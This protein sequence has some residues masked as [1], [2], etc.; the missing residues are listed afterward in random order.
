M[1]QISEMPL[2]IGINYLSD[3]ASVRQFIQGS[4]RSSS[5][6]SA[7]MTWSTIAS[8]SASRA[9]SLSVGLNVGTMPGAPE[10][11]RAQSRQPLV[12][13]YCYP[14]ANYNGTLGSD[15]SFV[16][17]GDDNSELNSLVTFDDVFEGATSP[18]TVYVHEIPATVKSKHSALFVYGVRSPLV[19][20]DADV[21]ACVVDAAWVD[22]TLNESSSE[23]VNF[24]LNGANDYSLPL[25]SSS[26]ISLSSSL[27][28]GLKATISTVYN[29]TEIFDLDPGLFLAVALSDFAA[30]P[31]SLWP[32]QWYANAT[33]SELGLSATQQDALAKYIANQGLQSRYSSIFLAIDEQWTDPASLT[34]Q[35]VIGVQQGYGYHPSEI[36]VKL[37]LAALGLYCAIV[38]VYLVYSIISGWTGS[39]W[40]SASDLVLL[41]LCSDRPGHL[42]S[43][44][45]G[46]STL[47]TFKEPVSI[48]H[49]QHSLELTFDDDPS[50]VKSFYGD[51]EANKEY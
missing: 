33:S 46:A 27:N 51:V 9:L 17:F 21:R 44:S 24:V 32:S 37:A 20:V 15:T 42:G 19:T 14:T 34:H 7:E 8:V 28:T 5:G 22:S 48:R 41:A 3:A 47:A 26:L 31:A 29:D 45:A 10:S 49:G 35:E 6:S 13:T 40:D 2:S 23:A 1:L 12:Q 11:L 43:V 36:T 30:S 4:G 18:A 16:N 39:S 50:V 25:A 38:T